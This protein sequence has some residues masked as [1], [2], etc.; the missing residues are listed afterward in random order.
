IVPSPNPTG[1]YLNALNGV[2]AIASDDVW[3]VGNYVDH[4]ASSGTLIEHWDGNQLSI[5]P[6]PNVGPASN[7]LSA[8][9]A[10][11]ANDVWAVGYYCCEGRG[12]I[13]LTEHWDGVQWSIVP[14]PNTST[15]NNY[16]TG[17]APISDSDVWTVGYANPSTG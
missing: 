3:M 17:I 4:S 12:A 2:S 7:H 15:N 13:T 14:S 11:S 6:S 16:L 9:A 8:V 1:A 5:V 10:S